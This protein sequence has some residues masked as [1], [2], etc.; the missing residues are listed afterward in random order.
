MWAIDKKKYDFPPWCCSDKMVTV[1]P[2]DIHNTGT[3]YFISILVV[4]FDTRQLEKTFVTIR[5]N[6]WVWLANM[7]K[8]VLVWTICIALPRMFCWTSYDP[9]YPWTSC[10]TQN[11]KYPNILN[12]TGTKDPWPYHTRETHLV[13][14]SSLNE[15][16]GCITH[17]HTS[18]LWI[19]A[20]LGIQL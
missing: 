6:N 19:A 14:A 2:T 16:K 11:N 3:I 7:S 8:P 10:V 4:Y 9:V 17:F 1:Y 15:A 12:T 13:A 5:W 20:C 18:C